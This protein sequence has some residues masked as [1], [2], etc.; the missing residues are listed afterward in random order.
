LELLHHLLKN[1][2][3][4]FRTGEKFI[5]A[6]RNFLCVSLLS[7]CTSQVAQ[8]TGLSLQIFILLMQNFKEHLKREVEVFVSTIFLRILESEN[9]TYEHKLRV[10]EVFH[11]ICRDPTTQIEIF[12]NY[13]CD[14]EAINLFT[15]IVSAFAKI[16]KVTVGKYAYN[17]RFIYTMF[18]HTIRIL[19]QAVVGQLSFCL[20]INASKLKTCRSV[21][22][23]SKDW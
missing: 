14:L 16:A 1:C 21:Q 20:Q 22:W 18:E 6:I 3:P 2:G 9:S 12:V 13:D 8:V 10:L 7:N 17:F 11:S 23:A 19:G 4:A 15:R 5:S